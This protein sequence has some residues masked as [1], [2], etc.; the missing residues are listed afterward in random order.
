MNASHYSGYEIMESLVLLQRALYVAM[1]SKYSFLDHELLTDAPRFGEVTTPDAYWQFI[2]HGKG[3]RFEGLPDGTVVDILIYKPREPEFFDAFRLSEYAK[4]VG[5]NQLAYAESVVDA[6]SEQA[7]EI[8][9]AS[10]LERGFLT[11]HPS[12]KHLYRFVKKQTG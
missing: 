6:T 12:D 10:L 4:S 8:Q 7:L 9:L 2:R 5:M 1:E 11:K 3:F